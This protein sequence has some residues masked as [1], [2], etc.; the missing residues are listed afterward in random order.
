MENTDFEQKRQNILSLADDLKR[1]A[2]SLNIQSLIIMVD[3]EGDLADPLQQDSAILKHQLWIDAAEIMGCHSI[4]VNLFGSEN[5]SIQWVKLATESMNELSKYAAPKNIN[6]IVENHGGYS[7]N[8]QLVAQVMQTIN[9]PNC[10]TLPDFGNFCIRREDG[11]RWEAPC[12]QEYD[13][14]QGI[15]EMMPYAKAVSAKT[16]SF[17][18]NGQE[19]TIDYEKM[20]SIVYENGYDGYLGV[21]W[22]SETISS[23]EGIKLTKDLILSTVEKLNTK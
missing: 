16:I 15:K 23:E 6:V 5:D 10:G 18:E 22:E 9:L 11:A 14:Y 17:D 13:K 19:T 7:C 8:G 2:D 12:I 3:N 21:E 1:R 4:R 20:L